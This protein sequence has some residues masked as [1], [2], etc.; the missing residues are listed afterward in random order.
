M[1]NT[2]KNFETK[3]K[4]KNNI[5][6]DYR[7][8]IA[9]V[10]DFLRLEGINV[11]IN[12]IRNLLFTPLETYPFKPN[13]GSLLYKMVFEPLDQIS[14]E[15]IQF[16]VK[17]RVYQWDSRVN[18]TKVA[19]SP[20]PDKKCVTVSVHIQKGEESGDIKLD[21]SNLPDFGLEQ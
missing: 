4:G 8:I 19:V 5:A 6:Y 18:I 9:P 1:S 2:L 21:F 13:Y 11:L 17:D 3:V 20:Q 10:G 16:E 7:D 14:L 15:Q 12:S